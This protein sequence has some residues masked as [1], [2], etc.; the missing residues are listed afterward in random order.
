MFS[1]FKKQ[2]NTEKEKSIKTTP[3]KTNLKNDNNLLSQKIVLEGGYS[4]FY[5]KSKTNLYLI[6]ASLALVSFASYKNITIKP[7]NAY[8]PVDNSYNVVENIPLT[9]SY[10]QED[11]VKFS[12]EAIQKT[13]SFNKVE[14]Q[15]QLLN[16]YNQYYTKNGARSLDN[17]LASRRIFD[18]LKDKLI[19]MTAKVT[20]NALII[21]QGVNK[22]GVQT[23]VVTVPVEIT[24]VTSKERKN[25]YKYQM[26]IERMSPI[27][28][29][30][31]LGVSSI[32][33]L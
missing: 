2:K 9:V 33:Q 3:P 15:E 6:I 13:F 31:G 7:E 17:E 14:Y 1:F 19:F 23:W 25:T 10:D 16:V 22:S 32:Q 20:E 8:L 30:S 5:Q 21:R 27:E 24:S 11:I 4:Y 29:L 28:R 12:N 18:L 26:T